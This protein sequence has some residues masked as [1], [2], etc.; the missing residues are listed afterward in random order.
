MFG[1]PEIAVSTCGFDPSPRVTIETIATLGHRAVAL[2][3]TVPELR[4]RN[5]SRSARRD[6]AALLRK[7]ELELAGLDLWIRP[8]TSRIPQAASVRSR[9]PSRRWS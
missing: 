3:V 1:L 5:L 9:P 4:P 2:D 6:L 8:S 7:A